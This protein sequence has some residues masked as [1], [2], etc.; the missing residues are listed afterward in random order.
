MAI[1]AFVEHSNGVE[2]ETST[3]N[4]TRG[5]KPIY[6]DKNFLAEL[7]ERLERGDTIEQMKKILGVSQFT[8]SRAKKYLRNGDTQKG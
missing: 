7:K 6:N 2:L 3:M 8:I 1:E 4:N 5:P